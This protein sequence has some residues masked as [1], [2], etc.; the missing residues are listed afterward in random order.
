MVF[1]PSTST[2]LL[3]RSQ[4][5][6]PEKCCRPLAEVKDLRLKLQTKTFSYVV[7]RGVTAETLVV[8]SAGI[9]D[10]WQFGFHTQQ[11]T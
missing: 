11:M 1:G 4:Q 9:G 10:E 2:I 6:P 3:P 5:S 8:M 7:S